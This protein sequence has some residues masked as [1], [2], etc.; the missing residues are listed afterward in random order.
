MTKAKNILFV[1]KYNRFRS[2]IAEALFN[3]FNKNKKNKAK[4]AGVIRGYPI[5]KEIINASK[6]LGIRIKGKPQGLSTEL[7]RWADL[8]ILVADDIPSLI[9]SSKYTKKLIVWRIRDAKN[10]KEL[11]KKIKLIEKRVKDLIKNLK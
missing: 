4:S 3:K 6:K 7:L 8:T 1:C 5:S 11:S 10:N 9:F 2:K